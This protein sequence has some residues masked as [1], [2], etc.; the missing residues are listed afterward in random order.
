[1]NDRA[2]RRQARR[3][4]RRAA[5]R[6]ARRARRAQSSAPLVRQSAPPVI[7]ARAAPRRIG[8]R[9]VG[10]PQGSLLSRAAPIAMGAIAATG[11]YQVMVR[12]GVS[13][14]VSR[15]TPAVVGIVLYLLGRKRK[16]VRGL[17]I[18]MIAWSAAS[19]AAPLV[20]GIVTAVIPAKGG[21]G[22]Q[23]PAGRNPGLGLPQGG[24]VSPLFTPQQQRVGA[25]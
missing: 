23:L 1:M 20:A 16:W 15:A 12:R 19:L 8:R 21:G 25:R 9:L 3:D 6:D 14:V 7:I 4:A 22:Q 10:N 18:G 11:T 17:G 24:T 5:R 13:P 2:A